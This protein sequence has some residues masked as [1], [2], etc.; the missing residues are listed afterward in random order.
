M[1]DI[2]QI[3]KVNRLAQELINHGMATDMQDAFSQAQH[4]ISKETFQGQ[5]VRSP[6][7]A[8]QTATV[9]SSEAPD[10]NWFLAVQRL[11]KQLEQQARVIEEL[12]ATI[13]SVQSDVFHIKSI[14]KAPVLS[15]PQPTTTQEIKQEQR[16]EQKP[17]VSQGFN[18]P[19]LA[20]N[21]SGN[22]RSGVFTPNDVSIEKF[23]YSGPGGG[24][25][26]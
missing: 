24:A 5:T 2:D 9:S 12:K 6:P 13:S 4:L 11:T 20:E 14:R 8:P 16:Q 23:F 18:R 17:K 19:Q 7:Y 10:N 1:I 25:R 15:T 26:G 21:G 22:P 3:Q